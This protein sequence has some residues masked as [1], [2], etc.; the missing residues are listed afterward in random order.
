VRIVLTGHASKRKKRE[1]TLASLYEENYEKVAWYIFIRIGN[2]HE[3]EDLASEVFLR[4]LQSL[5]SYQERGLPM[6]AWLFKIAHNL[7]VDY[8]RR[9]CKTRTMSIDDVQVADPANPEE[10]A[11]SDMQKDK[12]SEALKNLPQ[13]HQEVISLRFFADLSSTEA[14][15]ILG[16]KPGAV[17]E[18]QRVALQS[19]RKALIVEGQI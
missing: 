1:Q 10:M 2:R 15:E 18:M 17:R 14:G 6:G 8:L 7:V 13:S 11:H 9:A 5:D 3:A 4:A 16:K 12:L 19:L